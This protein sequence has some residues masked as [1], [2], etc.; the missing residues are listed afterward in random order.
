VLL[1]GARAHGVGEDVHEVALLHR[2]VPHRARRPL[3]LG[4]QVLCVGGGLVCSVRHPVVTN[5]R[6][7]SPTLHTT[8]TTTTATAPNTDHHTRH[9]TPQNPK[10][11]SSTPGMYRSLPSPSNL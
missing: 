2:L 9:I 11:T 1:D 7:P 8:S 6:L 4:Q 10:P 5:D 3:I